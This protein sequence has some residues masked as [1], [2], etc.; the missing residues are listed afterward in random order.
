MD[1]VEIAKSPFVWGLLLGLLFF[2]LSAWAHLKTKRDFRRY[3]KHLSDK[4]DL[5]AAQLESLKRERENLLRENENLRLR[6]GMMSEKPDQKIL[7]DLEILTR[8]EKRMIVRAP[9]F[10]P[11]WEGAKSEAAEEVALEES[12]KS[13]PKRVFNRL[14]GTPALKVLDSAAATHEGT[15]PAASAASGNGPAPAEPMPPQPKPAA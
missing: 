5:D 4:L 13:L 7:R 8:A 10:A 6:I 3:R 14:F 9:G 2:C 11:A 12:G 15:E 1:W